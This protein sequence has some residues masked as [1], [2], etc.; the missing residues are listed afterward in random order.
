MTLATH[1]THR[2]TH[3]S[4]NDP[5]ATD[6][7]PELT[8]DELARRYPLPDIDLIDPSWAM[9]KLVVDEATLIDLVN[10]GELDAFNLD[11]HI[12]FRRR[13]VVELTLA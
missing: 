1:T 2:Q 11:G 10:Q 13:D 7:D 12:R 4:A 9:N 8:G 5:L 6:L 3:C